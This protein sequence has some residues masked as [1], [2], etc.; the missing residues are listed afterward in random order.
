MP[1]CQKWPR[2]QTLSIL[3]ADL[4]VHVAK[5]VTA[6]YWPS[7]TA[8]ICSDD[9]DWR[10]EDHTFFSQC[11]NVQL[12]EGSGMVPPASQY[13][14]LKVIIW[15]TGSPGE[16]EKFSAF[17][18]AYSS[19]GKPLTG[20]YS[21][22]D[23]GSYLWRDVATEVF[24]EK[25]EWLEHLPATGWQPELYPHPDPARPVQGRP[26]ILRSRQGH[27]K[28]GPQPSGGSPLSGS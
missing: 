16:E 17:V 20:A 28:K 4:E 26:A 7:L 22:T 27:Q 10:D 6:G 9:M 25:W 1:L 24:C 5:G 3:E 12:L 19:A 21:H 18:A 14:N 23:G 13:P 8:L 11:I 15:Q 2:L